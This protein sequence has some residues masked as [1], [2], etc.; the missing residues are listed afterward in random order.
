MF[1]WNSLAF[2]MIQQ[3]FAIWGLKLLEEL[4]FMKTNLWEP[5]KLEFSISE[6]GFRTTFVKRLQVI[7][8]VVETLF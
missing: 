5:L 6:A 4:V 7:L 3:M 8:I 2:S 1:F